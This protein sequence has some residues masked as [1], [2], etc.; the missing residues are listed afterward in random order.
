MKKELFLYG[1]LI[2]LFIGY[3]QQYMNPFYSNNLYAQSDAGISQKNINREKKKK[4][5]ETIKEDKASLK[6]HQDIQ[7]KATR[8][9]MKKHLKQTKKNIKDS[10]R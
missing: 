1:C 3:S 7:T 9:R 4:M 10:H 5:R 2:L 8:N 6:R